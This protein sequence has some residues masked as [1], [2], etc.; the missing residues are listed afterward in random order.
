MVQYS[1]QAPSASVLA[2]EHTIRPVRV[3]KSGPQQGW[4][5]S[6]R[7]RQSRIDPPGLGTLQ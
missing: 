6:L 1:V 5:K 2:W 4:P 7:A 3:S